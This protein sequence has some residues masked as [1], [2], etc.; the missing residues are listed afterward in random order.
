MSS[1]LKRCTTGAPNKNKLSQTDPKSVSFYVFPEEH[2][3]F[4]SSMFTVCCPEISFRD[5]PFTYLQYVKRFAAWVVVLSGNLLVFE[6][7][8]LKFSS[9]TYLKVG[10]EKGTAECTKTSKVGRNV[11]EDFSR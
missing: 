10:F 3:G 5:S 2:Q 6:Q 8:S 9:L 4:L 7:Q 1:I 11:C